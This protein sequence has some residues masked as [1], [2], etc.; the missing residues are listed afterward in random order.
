M[1]LIC[2]ASLR[3]DGLELPIVVFLSYQRIVR[4]KTFELVASHRLDVVFLVV[5]DVLLESLKGF[6][7]CKEVADRLVNHHVCWR[8]TKH[9]VAKLHRGQS[10]V[11]EEI[12]AHKF[13]HQELSDQ[14][15]RRISCENFFDR[16]RMVTVAVV[17][18][19]RLLIFRRVR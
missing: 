18:G 5:P 17:Y 7:R 14:P 2:R 10:M 13:V 4:L 16:E 15:R 12:A 9:A 11:D 1:A 19:L 6:A 3:Q 8:N